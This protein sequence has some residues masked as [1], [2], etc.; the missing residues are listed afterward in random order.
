MEDNLKKAIQQMKNGEETGFNAVYSATYNRVYFRAKQI[1]KKE[2]DAEDLTQIVF[3]EAYKNIHTL[4]AS[5]VLYSWLDGITYNQGMKIYRKRKEILLMEE[6]EGMFDALESNDIS[7]MPELTADQRATAEILREII[8]EL[9]EAQKAA[10]I[11][12][13]FDDLKVE[14]IA[15]LMEC[16]TNTVKSRLNYARKYMKQRVE[17]KERIRHH[18]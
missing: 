11:A 13:Y 1:M 10:V 12:Y 4:Q 6:A 8:A 15:E 9:P 14:K 3:A 2:E 16:S 18:D 7:S 5:E 17:E